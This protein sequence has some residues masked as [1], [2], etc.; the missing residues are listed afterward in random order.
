MHHRLIARSSG[1]NGGS[2]GDGWNGGESNMEKTRAYVIRR[3]DNRECLRCDTE[4]YDLWGSMGNA[5][6][7]EDIVDATNKAT[8][9]G[10][11]RD[12]EWVRIPCWIEQVVVSVVPD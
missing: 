9:L 10:E 4:E 2:S 8:R 7:F 5:T 11:I 6:L 12:G 1:V 3:L